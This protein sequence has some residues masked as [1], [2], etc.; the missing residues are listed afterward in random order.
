MS[1]KISEKT[2]SAKNVSDRLSG[3]KNTAG[4][5]NLQFQ[6]LF[7]LGRIAGKIIWVVQLGVRL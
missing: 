3:W 1:R 5:L 2:R 7:I 4:Y 6:P